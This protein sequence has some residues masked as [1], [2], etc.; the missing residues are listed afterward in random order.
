LADPLSEGSL[1]IRIGE[2][3]FDWKL[4]LGSLMPPKMCPK[5]KEILNGAWIYCPWHGEK[6]VPAG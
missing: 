1:S 3:S 4:P 2:Q 5:D 6:L